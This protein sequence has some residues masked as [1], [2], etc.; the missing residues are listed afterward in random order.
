[1]NGSWAD[2]WKKK[3][4]S[5]LFNM[6]FI[7]LENYPTDRKSLNGT[8]KQIVFELTVSCR[9]VQFPEEKEQSHWGQEKAE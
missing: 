6:G 4:N 8:K 3:G 9:C 5:D 2:I 1:M 7:I